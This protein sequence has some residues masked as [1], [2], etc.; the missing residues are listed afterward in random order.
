MTYVLAPGVEVL[1]G[2]G[3]ETAAVPN[4]TLD[5]MMTDSRNVRMALGGR[6]AISTALAV[7]LGITGVYYLS[8]N[9]TGKSTLALAEPPSRQADGG[10]FYELWLALLDL[11]LEIRL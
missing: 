1:T 11:G 9:N 10:G 4:Q 6:V 7:T 3:Y 8:R 5:P 2:A